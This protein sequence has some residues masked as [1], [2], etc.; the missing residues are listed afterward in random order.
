MIVI[1]KQVN[2]G[3]RS[4]ILLDPAKVPILR[5]GGGAEG[6]GGKARAAQVRAA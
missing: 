5:E 4:D 6:E 2:D 3:N 1:D